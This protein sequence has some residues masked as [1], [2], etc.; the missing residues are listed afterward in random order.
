MHIIVRISETGEY[1]HLQS[2][3][4]GLKLVRLCALG[5]LRHMV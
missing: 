2:L 3:I 4:E 5:R 1:A